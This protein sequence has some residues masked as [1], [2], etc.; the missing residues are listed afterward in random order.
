LSL[1]P[2]RCYITDRQLKGLPN[3]LPTDWIQIRD[4]QLQAR[5]LLDLTRRAMTAASTVIVN[6]RMDVALAA[7]AA[8]LHLPADAPPTS[9]FRVIAPP[10]FL[11]GKSCHTLDEVGTAEQEGADYVFFA[12]IFAPLSKTSPLPPRGLDALAQAARAVKI[13]VIALGGITRENISDCIKAG[14]AGIAAISLF[15]RP[16][17]CRLKNETQ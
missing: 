17:A 12:P 3:T 2:L 9:K 7:G 11:I 14:A 10:A 1:P 4:K 15:E 8:G 16:T 6:T 5:D 13:P